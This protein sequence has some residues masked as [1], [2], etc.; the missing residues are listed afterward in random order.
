MST[1]YNL[2]LSKYQVILN[3]TS[4]SYQ[5]TFGPNV[6]QESVL[7][8]LVNDNNIIYVDLEFANGALWYCTMDSLK[9][10][11]VYASKMSIDIIDQSK[12]II[13][14]YQAFATDNYATDTSY[15]STVTN[16]LNNVSDIKSPSQILGNIRMNITTNKQ[17]VWAGEVSIS[18]M[19]FYYSND[20]L[21]IP[22]KA[23][24]LEFQN[25]SLRYFSDTW[26][27]LSVG[28]D[29]TLSR[30]EVLSMA[31]AAAQK[32]TLEFLS[33][34]G[35][36]Y[37]VKPDL[38]NV[39]NE[40]KFAY[41]LRQSTELYPLWNVNYYFN[42][43]YNG[44]YGIQIA[45]WGDTQQILYCQSLGTLGGSDPATVQPNSPAS[46]QPMYNTPSILI[47]TLIAIAVIGT[48]V[49]AAV[50]IR[51]KRKNRT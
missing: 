43:S 8:T 9:G 24:S 49:L 16:I 18:N 7:Y 13:Q 3:G 40:V 41:T 2:D 33:E 31:W 36:I 21:D 51:K 34:N 44:Y 1:I 29:N 15:I 28:A 23:I 42:Q 37:E 22:R 45:I 11:P 25:G 14:N 32:H 47:I 19:N 50:R 30:D 39:T 35:A 26:N 12:Q 5:S 6:R 38:T 4:A 17:Q 46:S 27:L 10:T 48:I 20:G